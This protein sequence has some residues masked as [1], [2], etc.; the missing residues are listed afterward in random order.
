[1][2][3]IMEVKKVTKKLRV[4][5]PDVIKYQLITEIVFFKNEHL[6]PSDLDILILLVMWGPMELVG[7]C[8][9]AAKHLYPDT[10]PQDLSVRSQ[11]VRNR[12]VKLEKRNIVIKSKTGR[13]VISLN[14]DIDVHSKGNILLDYNYLSVESTKA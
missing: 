1:L 2:K 14:P 12:I 7:F 11:N 10:A 4:T 3:D 9:N 5:T 13:K 6:I 8:M